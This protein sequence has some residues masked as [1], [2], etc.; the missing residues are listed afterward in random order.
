MRSEWLTM[1]SDYAEVKA[2]EVCAATPTA[3]ISCFVTAGRVRRG[4]SEMC[5]PRRARF[6]RFEF[7]ARLAQNG[8]FS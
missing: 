6:R 8:K 1:T 5:E 3:N 7:A 2:G 4:R